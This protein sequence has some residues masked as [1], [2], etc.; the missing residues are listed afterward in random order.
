MQ[1]IIPTPKS[2]TLDI[3]DGFADISNGIALSLG[4]VKHDDVDA[5]ISRLNS[6]GVKENPVGLPL[7]LSIVGKQG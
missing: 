7:H 3:N 4:N 1:A 6:L 5:A 2:V